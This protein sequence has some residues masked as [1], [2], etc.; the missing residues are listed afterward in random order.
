ML[1]VN[2]VEVDPPANKKDTWTDSTG[3]VSV[4]WTGKTLKAHIWWDVDTLNPGETDTLL[5]T[6][7]T[8]L[9]SGQGK[10]TPPGQNEYTSAGIHELNSGATASGMLGDGEIVVETVPIWVDV[11]PFVDDTP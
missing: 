5:L 9:N 2:G 1:A 6:V 8:D 4:L 7:S 3:N 10:K 11:Q